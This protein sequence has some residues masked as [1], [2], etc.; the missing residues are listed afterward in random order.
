M[1]LQA[2]GFGASMMFVT[3]LAITMFLVPQSQSERSMIALDV[4]TGFAIALGAW[5][6]SWLCKLAAER[7]E[8][9]DPE[10]PAARVI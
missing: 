10:L 3:A 2:K 1:Q 7:L 6:L 8:C 9:A 4:L 5:M